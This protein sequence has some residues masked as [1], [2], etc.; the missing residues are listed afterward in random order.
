MN[1]L[2]RQLAAPHM[3]HERFSRYG[4]STEEDYYEFYPNELEEFIK[5]IVQEC[6][7]YI[8]GVPTSEEGT[9]LLTKNFV[10]A[11]LKKHLGVK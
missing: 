3:M 11:N 4:E 9:L 6:V 7:N 2:I 1:E 5:T 8:D 10:I